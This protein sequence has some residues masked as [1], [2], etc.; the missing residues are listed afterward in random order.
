MTTLPTIIKNNGTVEEFEQGK[1][2]NAVLSCFVSTFGEQHKLEYL[3]EEITEGVFETLKLEVLKGDLLR[4]EVSVEHVH[5]RVE[6]QLLKTGQFDAAKEYIAYRIRK[7]DEQGRIVPP[8]V[9][10][11]FDGA[12][13]YFPQPYQ[14]FQFYDKYS[15]FD[16][17]LGR[18]ET[19]PET[20]DR[21]TKYL[22][23]LAGSE[24]PDSILSEIHNSILNLE[25]MPSMRLL[26]MAGDAARRNNTSIYNCSFQGIDHPYAFVETLLISMAGCGVGYSVERRFVD[27]LPQVTETWEPSIRDG[28]RW[29]DD[30]RVYGGEL[31]PYGYD[32]TGFHYHGE[33]KVHTVEDSACGWGMALY[34]GL[35]HWFNGQDTIEFDYS[36]VRPAGAVLKTKG[37]TSSGPDPL[38]RMLGFIRDRILSRKGSKL[39][40]VDVHDI[41]CMI[42]DCVVQGGVRRSAMISLFDWDDKE[43]RAAKSGDWWT[44]HPYRSN[45]NNSCVWP[46]RDLAQGELARFFLEMDENGSGEPGIFS[47]RNALNLMPTRR[48][49][50]MGKGAPEEVGTNPCGE[51]TLRS[52]QFCNLTIAVARPGLSLLEMD[53]RVHIASI[54]GTIQSMATNFVGLRDEWR[55]NCEAER[56]LG[57]DITGQADYGFFD[58]DQLETLRDTAVHTNRTWAAK[59]GINESASVT[60]E[61]PGG[62]S[63]IFLDVSSGLG[64]RWSPY[65]IRRMRL[66]AHGPMAKVLKASGLTLTPENGETEEN[67]STYVVA[68][69]MRTPSPDSPTTREKCAI[70]QCEVWKLNK[71]H[72]TEHNPSVTITY[73]PDEVLDVINWLYKNQSIIGGMAFLPADDSTYQQMPNEEITMGEYEDMVSEFPNIDFSKLYAFETH[74]QTTAAQEVAC[75]AGAC[76]IL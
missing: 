40:T 69:P 55:Q 9:R 43:M 5:D 54:I 4:E 58:A 29:Y 34:M 7:R 44:K 20:V 56:L 6:N 25:V 45:A 59:F 61:K 52:K 68:F 12:K 48:K 3:A 50:K 10:E 13:Q 21:V 70:A 19:W 49:W 18:R 75:S 66:S 17:E 74:D 73:R 28:V 30:N 51:I 31:M 76:S 42:G 53:R 11:V 15:K 64:R 65:Q 39:S 1:I 36:E 72:W 2:R 38:R 26:A 60:C 27:K 57:V 47:R 35:T 32:F 16:H 63:G 67:V 41:M 33:T 46:D 24:L 23:E 37:G 22:G 8:E 14:E 71:L 62:N